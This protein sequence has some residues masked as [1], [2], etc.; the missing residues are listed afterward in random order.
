MTSGQVVI[1]HPLKHFNL[2][3]LKEDCLGFVDLEV[4]RM[5]DAKTVT[6]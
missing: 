5:I 4:L 3:T 1:R 6:P 2:R